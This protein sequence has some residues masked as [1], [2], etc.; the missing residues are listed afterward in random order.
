M[1]RITIAPLVLG[2]L[3]GLSACGSGATT[4]DVDRSSVDV[5]QVFRP[6]QPY[7]KEGS[8]AVV[9]FEQ[10]GDRIATAGPVSS[11]PKAFPQHLGKLRLQPGT[12]R[13]AAYQ[14]DCGPSFECDDEAPSDEQLGRK[15]LSCEARLVADGA[16]VDVVVF[17]NPRQQQC[18]IKTGFVELG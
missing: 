6:Q 10:N 2:F 11:Q 14:V 3:L 17:V 4:S 5:A 9:T 15:P 7:G 13:V 1:P 18:R 8:A 12:Y 16:P